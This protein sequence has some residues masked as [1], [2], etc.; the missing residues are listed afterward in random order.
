MLINTHQ[1]YGFILIISVGFASSATGMPSPQNRIVH[2]LSVVF[3]LRASSF[4]LFLPFAG[5]AHHRAVLKGFAQAFLVTSILVSYSI[6]K[7]RNEEK[8]PKHRQKSRF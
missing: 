3:E 7:R 2:F 8:L 5:F 1:P 6:G 4:A